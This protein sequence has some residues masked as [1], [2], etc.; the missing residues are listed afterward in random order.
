MEQFEKIYKNIKSFI[1]KHLNGKD[2]HELD[3]TFE[4]M[5]GLSNDIYLVKIYNKSTNEKL[6]EVIYRQFGEISDLVDR[7]METKI[8]ENLAEKG[9]GPEIY[10]TDG[11]TFRIEEFISN[12]ETLDGSILKEEDI[13]QR[14]INILVSYTMISGVYSYHLHCK[15]FSQDYKIELDPL[16]NSASTFNFHR[17][18]QNMFDK[19][20]KEMLLKAKTNFEKFSE[21]FKKKYTKILDKEIFAKYQKV[22][23]YLDNYNQI[24]QKILPK[25][26]FLA[27][28]HNDVHRLNMLFGDNK[29]KL[30][31]LDH[32]YASLNLIGIDIV[33]YLIES[34]FDYTSKE[35]PYY[36]F[37]PAE[38]NFE[39]YFEIFKDFL[40]QF[41][42]SHPEIMATQENKHQFEKMRSFKYFLR[43]VCIA[44]LF[45]LLF[46]VIYC[47]FD[48]FCLQK[49]FDYFQHALDRIFFFEQAYKKLNSLDS[50]K[51]GLEAM[52]EINL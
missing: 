26:G 22:K 10:E 49:T 33:N 39:N 35:Y 41:E 4:K 32:E 8:I 43:L 38:I 23:H 11:K 31:L 16:I 25:K 20:M 17:D 28:N 51:F 6:Q 29:E 7:Q 9:L 21:K 2:Y 5:N 19:C 24:F 46:S 3:L 30:F 13:I 50:I 44:S 47:E 12:A 42:L 27:L 52:N 48:S 40:N 14:I 15:D 37:N 18:P 36:E 45:W 1:L 34:N